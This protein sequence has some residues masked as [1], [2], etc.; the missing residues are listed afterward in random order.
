MAPPTQDTRLL[1]NLIK[2]DKDTILSFKEYSKHSLQASSALEAWT[3]ND[4]AK[5]PACQHLIVSSFSPF[6]WVF[7]SSSSCWIILHSISL[8][9]ESRT[10]STER[11]KLNL[12]LKRDPTDV[13][14]SIPSQPIEHHRAQHLLETEQ[15]GNPRNSG[16]ILTFFQYHTDR[17]QKH[18]D[19]PPPPPPRPHPPAHSPPVPHRVP[20]LPPRPTQKNTREGILNKDNTTR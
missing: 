8:T 4:A 10:R 12:S 9:R 13:T 14:C 18:T 5:R 7:S 6:L 20:H 16:S 19:A 1:T 11:G 2:L 17:F 15:L 3:E